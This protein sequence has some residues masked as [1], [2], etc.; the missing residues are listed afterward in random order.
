[1]SGQWAP[2][3]A[4]DESDA[5]NFD[6]QLSKGCNWLHQYIGWIVSRG[7]DLDSAEL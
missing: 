3:K 4:P 2:Y 5:L 7:L 6:N 1:M